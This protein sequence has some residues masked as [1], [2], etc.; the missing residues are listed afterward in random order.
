MNYPADEPFDEFEDR[1]ETLA[2]EQ[3]FSV[4]E[5]GAVS[6]LHNSN[7]EVRKRVTRIGTRGYLPIALGVLIGGVLGYRLAGSFGLL[8]GVYVGLLIGLRFSH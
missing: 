4:L 1:P 6:A 3:T 2:S 5:A 7:P 8:L